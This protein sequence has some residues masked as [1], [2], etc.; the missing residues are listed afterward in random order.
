MTKGDLDE[1]VTSHIKGNSKASPSKGKGPVKARGGG[2]KSSTSQESRS[3]PFRTS[4]STDLFLN[5]VLK[6]SNL[7]ASLKDAFSESKNLELAEEKRGLRVEVTHEPFTVG[8]FFNLLQA[9]KGGVEKLCSKLKEELSHLEFIEKNND[10]Y[11]FHQTEDL[12]S[13]DSPEQPYFNAFKSVL[14]GEVKE[15]V[16]E[17]TG[18]SLNDNI[19]LF[20]GKYAHTDYL[21]C[22]D[23]ELEGRR[24]AFIFY[25]VSPSWSESDGG[26]LDLFDT[27]S[28]GEP[29]KVVKS[30]LPVLNSF[31]FFPVNDKSYHQVAEVLSKDNIRLSL[32]GWFHADSPAS[33]PP[34]FPTPAPK[35]FPWIPSSPSAVPSSSSS[36]IAEWVSPM[37]FDANLA[38]T[39][40]RKFGKKSEIQLENFIRLEKLG[41]VQRELDDRDPANAW[42]VTGPA[43]KSHYQVTSSSSSSSADSELD[44]LV[45]VFRSEE[46]FFLLSHLTGLKIHPSMEEEEEEEDDGEDSD[47]EPEGEEEE[48]DAELNPLTADAEPVPSRDNRGKDDDDEGPPVKKAKTDLPNESRSK[49]QLSDPTASEGTEEEIDCEQR[50]GEQ[51]NLESPTCSIEIRRWRPSDYS[52]LGDMST[53]A[54][55]TSTSLRN[56]LS[57][58]ELDVSLCIG[59]DDQWESQRHGGATVYV[60]KDDEDELLS[61]APQH[62]ALSL[63]FREKDTASFVKYINSDAPGMFFQIACGFKEVDME[64]EIEEEEIEEE[65]EEQE[66]KKGDD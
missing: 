10:L 17:M 12:S 53:A 11:Q 16:E 39:V 9:S 54:L 48:Q 64:V 36:L 59:V 42:V 62:N 33:R 49:K 1:V 3:S 35:S 31:A 52:L 38:K 13:R 5:P 43:N 41:A 51:A 45:S 44:K 28:K 23:D 24:I 34:R 32:S 18:I 15:M 37:Y 50:N 57:G 7:L 14:R 2:K 60:A 27:D 66:Q 4:T 61:I 6:Q 58:S 8:R 47:S 63:V 20:C 55:S 46:M 29:D 30:L 25:L 22:H 56:L 19:D 65:E 40:K 21:L 26:S